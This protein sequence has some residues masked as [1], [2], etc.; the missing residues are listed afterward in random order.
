MEFQQLEML[1]AVVEEGSI[2]RAAQRVCRTGPAVSIALKKL[3]DE[4]GIPLFERDDRHS[5]QLTV[6]GKL[7]YEHAKRILDLRRE[8]E[9]AVKHSSHDATL[10]IGTHESTSLYLLPSLMA[11]LN[12]THPAIKTE[13]ICGTAD[14]LLLALT[15]RAIELALI[16]DAPEDTELDSYLLKRDELIV[17]AKPNHRLS[18]RQHISVEDLRDEYLIVQGSKSLLRERIVQAMRASGIPFKIGVENV[19]IEAIKRMVIN[20]LGIGFVP[21]MCV[22]EEVVNGKLVALKV[23]DLRTDWNISLVWR[24]DHSLSRIA[25]DFVELSLRVSPDA[26]SKRTW[27]A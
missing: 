20:G 23:D 10:R 9:T 1:A 7:L 21:R 19:G 12:E 6:S 22:S 18:K 16:G 11:R 14:R 5:H 15:N 3:E 27:A 25:R 8:A 13:V 24:K 4:M 17:I 26:A 2:S